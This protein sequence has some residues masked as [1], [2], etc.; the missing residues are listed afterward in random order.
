MGTP[1][2]STAHYGVGYGPRMSSFAGLPH[3]EDVRFEGNF[4]IAQ[5]TFSDRDFPTLV[6]LC[7][8]NPL[9]PHDELNSG[10]PAAFFEW[11]IENVTVDGTPI[12]FQLVEGKLLLGNALIRKELWLT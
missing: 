10:L 12:D 1:C 2:A 5:L 8:F 9:I 3:F 6:H 11:E 4:P 7:A